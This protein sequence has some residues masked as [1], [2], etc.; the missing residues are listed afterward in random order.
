MDLKFSSKSKDAVAV[1][2]KS[3]SST[4]NWNALAA[5][6]SQ[7]QNLSVLSFKLLVNMYKCMKKQQQVPKAVA[8]VENMIF[9]HKVIPQHI[10]TAKD[11]REWNK[12]LRRFMQF[13][14][15]AEADTNEM[16]GK[17]LYE[18]WQCFEE[19]HPDKYSIFD[20]ALKSTVLTADT[21]KGIFP[22]QQLLQ[23]S[24]E[25][26]LLH[27][28]EI[29]TLVETGKSYYV[30][31]FLN[32]FDMSIAAPEV[33][34]VI[35]HWAAQI[36]AQDM[37]NYLETAIGLPNNPVNFRIFAIHPLGLD[38]LMQA[39]CFGA[40]AL[41]ENQF[42]AVVKDYPQ[43]FERFAARKRYSDCLADALDEAI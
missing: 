20:V 18:W 8:C 21:W 27:C 24:S 35:C 31:H 34:N 15:K 43:E 37:Q 39:D 10:K 6:C 16:A 13:F 32:K 30:I 4:R 1:R 40:I 22:I 33:K 26:M 3:I 7:E 2:L 5:F 9:K 17:L 25:E 14:G 29:K 19:E 36:P 28:G 11:A 42:K 23:D 38:F 41:M 12:N